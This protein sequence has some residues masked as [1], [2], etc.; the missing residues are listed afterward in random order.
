MVLGIDT[1]TKSHLHIPGEW[2]SSGKASTPGIKLPNIKKSTSINTK[3]KIKMTKWRAKMKHQTPSLPRTSLEHKEREEIG[4]QPLKLS[5]I[6][7][8]E[9]KKKTNGK[10]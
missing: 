9:I 2:T 10:G 6:I 8:A 4:S 3:Y 1:E 5:E 7:A